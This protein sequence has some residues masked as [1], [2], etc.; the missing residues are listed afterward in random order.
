M[1]GREEEQVFAVVLD[2]VNNGVSTVIHRQLFVVFHHARSGVIETIQTKAFVGRVKVTAN[3]E[4]NFSIDIVHFAIFIH[5]IRGGTIMLDVLYQCKQT[6][7]GVNFKQQNV[8]GYR[9]ERNPQASKYC[10]QLTV[11]GEYGAAI[12]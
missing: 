5:R 9:V 2:V 11:L 10:P 12:T 6:V 8:V 3:R 7:S 4:N 1:I